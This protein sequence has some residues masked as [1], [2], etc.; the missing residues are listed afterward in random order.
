MG[1]KNAPLVD[2]L[3]PHPAQRA[4]Q[5][6]QLLKDQ[7]P[8]GQ[9]QRLKVRGEVDVFKG[10]AGLNQFAAFTN[11]LRQNVRQFIAAEI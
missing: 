9:L 10:I 11:L 5:N 3:A 4:G 1:E 6:E 2:P 8:P 7:P